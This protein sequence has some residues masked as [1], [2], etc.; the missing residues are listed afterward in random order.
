MTLRNQHL[1]LIRQN[2][3][4]AGNGAFI[5]HKKSRQYQKHTVGILLLKKYINLFYESLNNQNQYKNR[6]YILEIRL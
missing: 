5:I 1:Y 6:E 2:F 3:R 4:A